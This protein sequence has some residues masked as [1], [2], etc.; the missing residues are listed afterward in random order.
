M[1]ILATVDRSGGRRKGVA[2]AAR[3]RALRE[4][5]QAHPDVDYDPDLFRREI[6][7]GLAGVKL[8]TIVDAIG[9]SKSFASTIRAGRQIPHVS[10]WGALAQIADLKT[11][12]W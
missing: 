3:K 8:A 11:A 12:P 9:C 4:W 6:L 1:A 7:P 5:D 10:T 2:I